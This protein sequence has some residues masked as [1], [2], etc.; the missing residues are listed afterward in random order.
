MVFI[1]RDGSNKTVPMSTLYLYIKREQSQT[2]FKKGRS[3]NLSMTKPINE[4]SHP[5]RKGRNDD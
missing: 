4:L 5:H 2:I 3:T 1:I